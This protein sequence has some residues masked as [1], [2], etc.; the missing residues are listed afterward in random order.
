MNNVKVGQRIYDLCSRI[1]PICRSLM[2]EGVRETLRVLDEYIADMG[3]H[4]NITEVPTDTQVY[5]WT[6]PKEWVIR[7]AYIE[8]EARNRIVDFKDNNLHVMGYSAP[9]DEWMD[10]SEMGEYIYTQPDQP[11]L[12]PYVTSYYKERFGFCMSEN[13]KRNLKPGMYHLYVDSELKEG[14]LTYADLVIKGKLDKEVLI[15][16]Y[17]CHPSM[18]N[19]ICSG[20]SLLSELIRYVA[21]LRERRY[22]YR[23]V[24]EPE[25]IGA[26]AYISQHYDE[27]K[28][29]VIA[30]FNLSCV[31]DDR[32]Y[33]MVESPYADTYSDRILKNILSSRGKINVYSY[34]ERGSDERQYAAAGIGIPMVCFCRSKFEEFP[35]Y[36][37]SA[38]N[39]SLVNP[40]GFQGSFDVMTEVI[41]VLEYNGKYKAN[42]LCEPQLGKRGLYP[43]ISQKG[44]YDDVMALCN[45][46][47]YADGRNDLIAISEYLHRS[48]Y[49]LL[50][51]LGK[52]RDNGLIEMVEEGMKTGGL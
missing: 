16:T 31:G 25:T 52:L 20:M 2:G 19:D 15:T 42:V 14:S 21:S 29:N 43:T 8:D 41:Q 44:Q 49:D 39:M 33:S 23:F 50:V 36:H 30:A 35:E 24:L 7:N 37:T 12:I 26:I 13:Q 17:I 46:V 1:F 38:D 9:V 47:A 18:A 5:D 32:T 28:E 48:A 51:P 4:F 10:L 45:F 40:A 6:V 3:Y 34:L 27:L 11:E 22:T